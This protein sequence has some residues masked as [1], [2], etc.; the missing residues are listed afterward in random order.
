MTTC[1]FWSNS[2]AN[3]LAA[4]GL[5]V[6]RLLHPVVCVRRDGKDHLLAVE[7]LCEEPERRES[8]MYVEVDRAGGRDRREIVA[9]LHRVLADVRAAVTDWQKM[10]AQMRAD[11]EATDDPEG[12]ALLRWF[13]D[14]A[15]T[16]LGYHVERPDRQ[17]ED[18]L[19]LF[20][21]PGEPTDPGGALGAM[22]WLDAEPASAHRQG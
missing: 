2:V 19:G 5:I 4:R 15:M 13:A 3:A 11:A 18:A 1:P 17:P 16:L 6:H 12:A 9:E 7:P 21:I 8:M 14:G 22:R 10:Q 20:R